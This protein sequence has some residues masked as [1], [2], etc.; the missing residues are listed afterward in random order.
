LDPSENQHFKKLKLDQLERLDL[1]QYKALPKLPIIVVCDNIRSANNIGSI[2][3]TSDA[4]CVEKILLTGICA[5]PPHREILKSALGATQSVE[6]TYCPSVYDA[7]VEEK[8]K[9][10]KA[11]A[12]EQTTSSIPLHKFAFKDP[13][14]LIF[15]NEVQGISDEILP[16]LEGCIEVPQF[17]TKHS[18]N[19]SVCAGIVLWEAQKQKLSKKE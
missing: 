2:F 16:L 17:G 11:I 18:L 13:L 7:V 19:V 9:G 1:S 15:G 3:R 8:K 14:L 5:V 4:M 10:Y 6:W 12:V